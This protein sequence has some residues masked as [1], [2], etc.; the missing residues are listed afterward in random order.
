MGSGVGSSDADVAQ[1]AGH[2]QGDD[3]G[4]VDA[5]VAYSVVAVGGRVGVGVAL[6]PVV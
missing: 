5:V 6:M 1:L 3:P 4:G 2:A